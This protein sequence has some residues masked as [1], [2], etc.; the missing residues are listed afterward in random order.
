M[1]SVDHFLTIRI[2]DGRD[3]NRLCP[4]VPLAE[5]LQRFTRKHPDHFD[6][7]TGKVSAASQRWQKALQFW[8][9][10]LKSDVDNKVEAECSEEIDAIRR[11]LWKIIQA[12]KKKKED[13]RPTGFRTV[14]L[15]AAVTIMVTTVVAVAAFSRRRDEREDHVDSDAQGDKKAQAANRGESPKKIR[16][17]LDQGDI[18]EILREVL[19]KPVNPITAT[20]N[21]AQVK[22]I[23]NPAEALAKSEEATAKPIVIHVKDRKEGVIL[24]EG[25][26][27]GLDAEAATAVKTDSGLNVAYVSEKVY[28]MLLSP[29]YHRFYQ[30][31]QIAFGN[32]VIREL[33]KHD[34]QL[35]DYL[36]PISGEL[37]IIPVT[38]NS[39]H[40]NGQNRHF[41]LLSI[42][43]WFKGNPGE[44][45]PC[46]NGVFSEKDLELDFPCMSTIIS[47]LEEVVQAFLEK[48]KELKRVWGNAH[49]E[50]LDLEQGGDKNHANVV[51]S[52]ALRA[53]LYFLKTRETFARYCITQILERE[54]KGE[55]SA[56]ESGWELC[57]LK[58]R[59]CRR[60]MALITEPNC[61]LRLFGAQ[62]YLN[63]FAISSSSVEERSLNDEEIV[64]VVEQLSE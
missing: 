43:N 8:E 20:L 42:L 13:T 34:S 59:L 44:I 57:D 53:S 3:Y 2:W 61:F 39:Q 15:A 19:P 21:K 24:T 5:A 33:V 26:I 36:C 49:V 35:C 4:T 23:V 37:P 22:V 6:K 63:G 60:K 41:D 12:D 10:T 51:V 31:R 1:S 40:A 32:G 47:R 27:V 18:K 45:P 52:N 29:A 55:I 50:A 14:V 28:E 16:T 58:L 7:T 64:H 30:L 17:L 25:D 11:H 38:V 54:K 56:H 48:S 62:P 9:G 46:C